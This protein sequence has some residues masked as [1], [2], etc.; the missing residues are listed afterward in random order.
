MSATEGN[1][2]QRNW[3][4]PVPVGCI[5]SGC[6]G[7]LAL[8]GLLIAGGAGIY[9]LLFGLVKSSGPYRTYQMASERV[10]NDPAVIQRLGQPV[11]VGW[12]SN[13]RYKEQGDKGKTCMI[14]SVS[15]SKRSGHVYVETIKSADFWNF[16]QLVVKVD[17]TPQPIVL[18]PLPK[19]DRSPLCPD[20][21][22]K[23]SPE[24]SPSP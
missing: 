13:T 17:G 10:E 12:M 21:E 23:D 3:K 15:G 2:W 7:F 18:V 8:L 6:L 14:F 24:P 5:A 9:S 11:S 22:F 4:C 1:W 20:S 19:G 16:R